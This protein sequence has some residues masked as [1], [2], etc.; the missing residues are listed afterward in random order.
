MTIRK[1]CF[2]VACMIIATQ[3]HAGGVGGLAKLFVTRNRAADVYGFSKEATRESFRAI[4]SFGCALGAFKFLRSTRGMGKLMAF[5]ESAGVGSTV[6]QLLGIMHAFVLDPFVRLCPWVA[7]KRNDKKGLTLAL[8]RYLQSHNIRTV[9]Q[10]PSDEVHG[11]TAEKMLVRL[12]ERIEYGGL[13]TDTN[14]VDKLMVQ[15]EPAYVGRIPEGLMRCIS[16]INNPEQYQRHGA[17][18]RRGMPLVGA[19]GGGKTTLAKLIAYYTQ[20]PFIEDSPASLM[21]VYVGTGPNALKDIFD[22]AENAALAAHRKRLMQR[23]Q[24]LMSMGGILNKVVKLLCFWR[25]P[26]VDAEYVKPAIL[27]L[28]EIDAIAGQRGEQANDHQERR[29]TLL[30]LLNSIDEHPHVFVVGTSNEQAAYFDK[31]LIRPGRM[32]VPVVIPLPE[33]QDRFEIIKYYM[34][35]IPSLSP[36]VRIPR[37]VR[38][39]WLDDLQQRR[40]SFDYLLPKSYPGRYAFWRSVVEQTDGFSG[41]ELRQLFNDA[42][43]VAGDRSSVY[44]G[45]AH[46]QRALQEML[47]ERPEMRRERCRAH[48][49]EE[50]ASGTPGHRAA[51]LIRDDE[52][53]IMD[54]ATSDI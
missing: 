36:L 33:A 42:A 51:A 19:P 24:R 28:N 9:D 21:K 17:T 30:Q 20:C 11:K 22:N 8:F 35:K 34:Y 50:Q 23:E 27:C 39:G 2:F 18:L 31:A 5:M 10:L 25:R 29:N 15:E 7:K 32:G 6:F 53:A 3:V 49:A 1:S 52:P 14:W 44:L 13:D 54:E 16:Y 45:R 12:Q 40:V 47:E 46:I 4:I 43:M 37:F 41:D 26:E 48:R 38:F